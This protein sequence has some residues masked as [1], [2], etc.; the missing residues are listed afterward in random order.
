MFLARSARSAL[1]RRSN[2][3][4]SLRGGTGIG[5]REGDAARGLGEPE[6]SELSSGGGVGGSI[7]DLAG[8]DLERNL[9]IG[10]ADGAGEAWKVGPAY[11]PWFLA[12][13]AEVVLGA[14]SVSVKEAR[15]LVGEKTRSMEG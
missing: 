4:S 8:T 10:S 15:A 11:A 5:A 13:V 12:G 3:E 2:G 1:K 6:D 14:V 7:R 9:G